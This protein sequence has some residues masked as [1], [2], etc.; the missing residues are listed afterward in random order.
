MHGDAP[1]LSDVIS[2]IIV[3]DIRPYRD[4]VALA[5]EAEDGISVDGTADGAA[6][7]VRLL[8]HFRPDVVLLDMAVEDALGLARLVSESAHVVALAVAETETSVIRC[9][10]AGAVGYVPRGASLPDVAAAVRSAVAGEA[11]CSPRIAGGLLRRL[12]ARGPGANGLPASLTPRESQ[13][14]TLIEQGMSNKE[15]A[16]RLCIA[17]ATVKNHVHNILEKLQVRRRAEAAAHLRR[18]TGRGPAVELG[19]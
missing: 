7:A 6:D 19:A 3:G 10:E 8:R 17:V 13:I 5:L 9:A 14:L 4:A 2:V 1:P 15:I 11:V 18:A 16:G 12:S